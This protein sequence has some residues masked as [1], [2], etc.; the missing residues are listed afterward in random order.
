MFPGPHNQIYT[1]Y[2]EKVL[3]TAQLSGV[4]GALLRKVLRLRPRRP[5]E[6]RAFLTATLKD[7]L[8][9]EALYVLVNSRVVMWD[10]SFTQVGTLDSML[11]S[12]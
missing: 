7:D 8:H 9:L 4:G 5:E 11:E 3:K 2:Q 12:T 6:L 10:S 1:K